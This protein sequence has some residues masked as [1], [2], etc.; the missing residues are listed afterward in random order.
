MV[1]NFDKIDVGFLGVCS[2]VADASI[3]LGHDIMLLSSQFP[4]Y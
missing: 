2:G 3:L 1:N 4:A